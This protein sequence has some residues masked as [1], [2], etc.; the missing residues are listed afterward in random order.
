MLQPEDITLCL[1]TFSEPCFTQLS[2][3]RLGKRSRLKNSGRAMSNL[4]TQI[5][6]LRKWLGGQ[7]KTVSGINE[8]IRSGLEK[9]CSAADGNA[10]EVGNVE[11]DDENKTFFLLCARMADVLL[12]S[13]TTNAPLSTNAVEYLTLKK[14]GFILDSLNQLCELGCATNSH[15]FSALF[16]S[17]VDRLVFTS[18]NN[19]S[20]DDEFKRL[21]Q[22]QTVFRE[23]RHNRLT[24]KYDF[25]FEKSLLTSFKLNLESDASFREYFIEKYP[26]FLAANRFHARHFDLHLLDKYE[27]ELFKG[28]EEFPR[29][30]MQSE[31]MDTFLKEYQS[32]MCQENSS[33]NVH[34]EFSQVEI[35]VGDRRRL[36]VNNY[37]AAILFLFNQ[38][39]KLSGECH[40]L[41]SLRSHVPAA[42]YIAQQLNLP[43]AKIK[44]ELDRLQENKILCCQTEQMF[45]IFLRDRE[46]IDFY[47]PNPAFLDPPEYTIESN[48]VWQKYLF[49]EDN[50][51]FHRLEAMTRFPFE[52]I[53][54]KMQTDSVVGGESVE[55]Q[56]LAVRETIRRVLSNGK[57]VDKDNLPALVHA[58]FEEKY[59]NI[60]KRTIG[61]NI[62]KML[63]NRELDE[64]DSMISLAV[65]DE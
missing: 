37:C 57:Q 47:F 15:F 48:L 32:A 38:S 31:E 46:H 21:D 42:N 45:N 22:L 61:D 39:E 24:V 40:F 33:V 8:N 25:A 64:R 20:I 41:F 53:M 14:N 3:T 17:M 4:L 16:N 9:F 51:S 12:T 34:H 62:A 52:P 35:A 49:T 28:A 1:K 36:V 13:K 43:L 23:S 10:T 63:I 6:L 26:N 54:E 59:F 18:S 55:P 2:N 27:G 29:L 60:R 11:S 58:E 65:L 7:R 56:H 50:A 19:F 44:Y 5:L 30:K